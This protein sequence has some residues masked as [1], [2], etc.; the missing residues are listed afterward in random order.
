MIKPNQIGTITET[1]KTV[2]LAQKHNYSCMISHRSGET[3]DTTIVHLAIGFGCK[4]IKIGSI[5]RSDRTA[6]YNELIRIEEFLGQKAQY[7]KL[8]HS[9]MLSNIS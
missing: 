8:S 2:K 9:M 3:E 1:I 5:C 6:K 4:Q 7:S